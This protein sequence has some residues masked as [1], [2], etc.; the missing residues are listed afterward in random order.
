[1][2]IKLTALDGTVIYQS[3][4]GIYSFVGCVGQ[5]VDKGVKT[6]LR[7]ADDEF[8]GIYF[9]KEAPEEILELIGKALGATVGTV[10]AECKR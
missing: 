4:N 9:V 1:M 7:V 8:S 10:L 2:F 5:L 3:I 6:E